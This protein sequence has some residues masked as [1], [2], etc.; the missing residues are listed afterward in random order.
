MPL[1]FEF[2]LVALVIL[3]NPTLRLPSAL[4]NK[5]LKPFLQPR[6]AAIDEW[7]ARSYLNM[8]I[9]ITDGLQWLIQN[10][11][12]IISAVSAGVKAGVDK[13]KENAQDDHRKKLVRK[14]TQQLGGKVDRF[15]DKIADKLKMN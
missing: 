14:E 5:I 4:Y 15:A 13:A 8:L 12:S 11:P 10:A 3:Q 6:E 9:S 7:L 2:K 1:Y